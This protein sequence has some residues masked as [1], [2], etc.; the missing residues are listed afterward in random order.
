MVRTEALIF[1][2]KIRSELP[3]YLIDAVDGSIFQCNNTWRK[4]FPHL[5]TPL[6]RTSPSFSPCRHP[7]RDPYPQLS[8]ESAEHSLEL[9]S[10]DAVVRVVESSELMQERGTG[11]APCSGLRF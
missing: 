1:K 7:T 8:G 11:K 3:V 10:S 9:L 5:A 2:I 4:P 6:G